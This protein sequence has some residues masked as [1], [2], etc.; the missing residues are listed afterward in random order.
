MGRSIVRGV[1][2]GGLSACGLKFVLGKNLADFV[3]H[4]LCLPIS[5]SV[6]PVFFQTKYISMHNSGNI[7][8][9]P[10][11]I[12][13]LHYHD[14]WVALYCY[15]LHWITLI[16]FCNLKTLMIIKKRNVLVL[17]YTTCPSSSWPNCLSA[18]LPVCHCL[19]LWVYFVF[20]VDMI[21]NLYSF[22]LIRRSRFIDVF[23][24]SNLQRPQFGSWIS[25]YLNQCKKN[26]F[27]LFV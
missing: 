11:L 8:L 7:L 4:S 12:S 23:P 2:A 21:L 3:Q 10:H 1:T 22:V 27:V 26:N 14:T 13:S 6:F 25:K 9:L 15:H 16:S 19:Y 5:L 17:L 18:C 20:W 24:G